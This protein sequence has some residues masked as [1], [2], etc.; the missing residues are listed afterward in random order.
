MQ[1]EGVLAKLS[2]GQQLEKCPQIHTWGRGHRQGT[3]QVGE[4]REQQGA[5]AVRAG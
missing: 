2:P 1:A 4:S 3:G 5:A